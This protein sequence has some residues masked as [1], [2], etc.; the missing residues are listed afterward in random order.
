MTVSCG[1]THRQNERLRCLGGR[2]RRN[3]RAQV[4]TAAGE[5]SA[6][7]IAINTDL[8]QEDMQNAL[9]ASSQKATSRAS[10]Q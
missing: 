2:E 9:H 10:A 8:I 7:A 4:I 5:G 3:P 6:A 1:W